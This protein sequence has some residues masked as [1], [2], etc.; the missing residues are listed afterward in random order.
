MSIKGLTDRGLSFPQIGNVRK[1]AK[2]TANAP[3]ADLK[4]FRVEFDEKE[5]QS[6]ALFL[7]KY[8]NQPTEINFVFPFNEIERCWEA[9]LEA[10]TA[11]RMVAR[12]DGE[13]F[14]YWL[15]D[16]GE[17]KVM[18]GVDKDGQKVPHVELVGK[19]YKGNPVKLRPVGRLRIVIPELQRLAYLVVHTTSKHDIINISEQL[20]GIKTIN[21][22]RLVGIPLV[23]RRRPR[24]I[25]TP[26]LNDKAKRVRR[27]KW[28]L[29]IEADPEWVKAK[30]MEV[31]RAALPG[32]GLSLLAQGDTPL[33][34]EEWSDEF[35][36][37]ETDENMSGEFEDGNFDPTQNE[38]TLDDE[39]DADEY[40]YAAMSID[41]ASS[42]LDSKGI[43][44]GEIDSGVLSNKTIGIG[45]RLKKNGLTPE[46]R[47]N[48]E[49]K[50]AA[51]KTILEYRQRHPVTA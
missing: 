28:L 47:E 38:Q 12:S 6:S 37:E 18:G 25:S 8:G 44:Y 51:I 4:Y 9:W 1:G 31:K 36:D 32:N 39:T 23:L 24:M 43:P 17:P 21:G 20:E 22:G 3:G 7:D 16:K 35:E 30:L 19:D 46:D 40:E 49:R 14:T 42:E 13:Y 15:D 2:K 34:V 11:G 45:K 26:D 5:P 27:E 50:L 33:Q 29:S 41:L 48:F 10:Y